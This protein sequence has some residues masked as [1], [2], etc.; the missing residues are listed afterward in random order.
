MYV[1]QC[2]GP[3]YKLVD[4]GHGDIR[5]AALSA[6]AQFAICLGRQPGGEPGKFNPK[7]VILKYVLIFSFKLI[8]VACQ[9]AL[10]VLIPKLVSSIIA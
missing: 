5:R 8:F 6:L 4:Y 7:S 3:I 1:E 10:T 2:S 9:T